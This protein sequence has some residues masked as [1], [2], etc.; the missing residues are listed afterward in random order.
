MAAYQGLPRKFQASPFTVAE[1]A[2]SGLSYGKLR[3]RDVMTLSRG[4]KALRSDDDVPLALLTPYVSGWD[5]TT[6]KEQVRLI[7][8]GENQ[9]T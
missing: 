8:W 7:A 6:V 5:G 4:I 1:A 3:H 2:Q 9:E